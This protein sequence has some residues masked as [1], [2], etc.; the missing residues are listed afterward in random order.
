MT[1]PLRVLHVASEVTP[2]SKTG[3]LAEV[4]AALPRALRAHGVAPFVITPRYRSMDEAAHPLARRLEPLVVTL[5]ARTERVVVYEAMLPGGTVPIFLLGHPLFDVDD[6]YV[7]PDGAGDHPDNGLRFALLCRAALELAHTYDLWPDLVHAHDWQGALA[8]AYAKRE[9]FLDRPIPRTLLTIHNLAFQGLFPTT[10]LGEVGLGW[11][12]YHPDRAE[13]YGQISFLKAGIAYA[14]RITTVSPRY[15]REIQS[16]EHGAGLDG[17]LRHHAPRLTGVLNGVDTEVWNPARDPYLAARYDADDLAG[18]AA[19]KAA[20]LKELGLPGRV[21]LPV[22]ASISR[23]TEQKGF[24]L[25][26]EAGEELA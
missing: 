2:F 12:L 10:V 7:G 15:A 11:D 13:F 4:V 6:P 25:I 16:Q 26:A 24:D 18:K 1:A 22:I 14:D 23:L 3:G 17:F 5:G 8:L 9:S 20:L 19:C 21:T